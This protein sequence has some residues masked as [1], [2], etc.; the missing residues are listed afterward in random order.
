[1][2]KI[3]FAISLTLSVSV[4]TAQ[5]QVQSLQ[6]ARL[7][8]FKNGTCLVKR[9][10]TVKVTE[11][12]FYINA[13]Q[14]VL[15]GTYWVFTGKESSLQSII[16][17]T[18]TFKVKNAP[19]YMTEF[20]E[21]SLGQTITLYR[22]SQNNETNK[23]TGKLVDYNKESGL[24]KLEAANG[25][26]FV[27]EG[28]YL[29]WLEVTGSPKGTVT[30]DSIIPVAKIKLD[31]EVNTIL[32]STLSLERGVQWFPSYLF[33]IINDKEA[34]LEM[35]AT[36][37]NGETEYRNTPVDII[38][39]NPEMFYGKTL[40]PACVDYLKE[41][42]LDGRYDNTSYGLTFMNTVTQAVR[43]AGADFSYEWSDDDNASNK[44]GTK[45]EDLYYYQL[46]LLDL[47]K[48]SRVIVPVM[49]ANVTY[50]EIYTANLPINSTMLEGDKSVQT[51]HSYLINNNSNAPFTTGAALVLNQSNQPLAQAQLTY[52]PVRGNSEMQL[53]KAVDVQVKNEEEETGRVKSTVKRSAS[54]YY[55]QINSS[56][57]I[58]ITNYKDKKITMRVTKRIDGVYAKS[59]NNGKSRKVKTGADDSDTVTE[60]YWEVEV[61]A[62]GKLQLKYDYYSLD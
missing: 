28:R 38:I 22:S 35:K 15:M 14:K 32:A 23:V 25:K 1:M 34:K 46:G 8:V 20:L 31:K 12:S 17:R 49:T 2:R 33:T 13:P 47:E 3:L 21:A 39:G 40:D 10:G 53:S 44:D 37:A 26:T 59:D 52:T 50:S 4:V 45:M 43:P 55:E 27:I 7:G 19:K 62:G 29:D 41:S 6:P 57:L 16:I 11:K 30:T 61:P 36:I 56:G 51:Y 9:E 58:T 24:V 60:L 48:N 18:D 54:V 42:M 5:K